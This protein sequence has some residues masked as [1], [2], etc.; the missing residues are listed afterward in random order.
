MTGKW[1][2]TGVLAVAAVAVVAFLTFGGGKVQPL[3]PG[4][5]LLARG[6]QPEPTAQQL[7]LVHDL[8]VCLTF[9]VVPF[10]ENN[11]K[12][13]PKEVVEACRKKDVAVLVGMSDLDF[14]H[15]WGN[16]GCTRM[17]GSREVWSDKDCPGAIHVAYIFRAPCKGP[18][19][20]DLPAYL[21]IDTNSAGIVTQA[22][23]EPIRNWNGPPLGCIP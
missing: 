7:A 20:V 14:F 11:A 10:S 18:W 12:S 13:V 5:Q 22:R 2:A 19:D 8:R 4:V 6:L 21:R 16:P 9:A 23:W 17:D 1:I 15:A 3:P